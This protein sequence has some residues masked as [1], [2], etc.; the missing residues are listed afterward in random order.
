MKIKEKNNQGIVI[1][2]F[3]KSYSIIHNDERLGR[4]ECIYNVLK[5][6]NLLIYSVLFLQTK[7]LV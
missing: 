6:S 4:K 3:Y 5:V 2:L 1:L 7:L